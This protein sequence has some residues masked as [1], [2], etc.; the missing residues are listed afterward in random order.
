[1]AHSH[2]SPSSCL[3]LSLLKLVAHCNHPEFAERARKKSWS[4]DQPQSLPKLSGLG[5]LSI[6]GSALMISTENWASGN[7]RDAK[8]VVCHKMSPESLSG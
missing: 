1:M 2:I 8:A 7:T 4:F 6:E 5:R 3:A